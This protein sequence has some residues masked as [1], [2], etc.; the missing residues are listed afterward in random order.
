MRPLNRVTSPRMAKVTAL[1]LSALLGVSAL[2]A[3]G[4]SP[5]AGATSAPAGATTDSGPAAPTQLS[6]LTW[7]DT[8]YAEQQG[9]VYNKQFPKNPVDLKV[10]SGG[11]NDSDSLDKFRLALSANSD[12]PDIVQM[13]YSSLPEFAESGALADLQSSVSP[14]LDGVTTAGQKLMQYNGKYLAV[15]YEVKTK[16][17]FYRS[18]LFQK[19][20][21]DVTKVKTQADFVAAGKQLQAVS[22]KSS[23]WNIGPNIAA[24]NLGMILSG[25]GAKFS[26]KTPTCK[27]TVDSDPGVKNGFVALKELRDSGVVNRNIDDWSPEWQTALADG[28]IASTLN[29]SWFPSFLQQYAPDLAGKWAV[30]TWPEI[31]GA[32]GGS[33]AAGSIFVIPAGAKHKDAAAAFLAG[34]LL[35]PTGAQAYVD[36]RGGSFPSAVKAVDAKAETTPNPYFG[37]SLAKAFTASSNNYTV[38]PYDPAGLKEAGVA[39]AQLVNYLNSKDTDPSSYL[40]TAQQELQSQVGCPFGN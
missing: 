15:P 34:T 10:V 3:C 19:A 14:Y 13:N 11:Q 25:N 9:Q 30:T 16:L 18:D 32:N 33:E 5:S 35:D 29:A 7:G 31:G 12:I 4:G 37:D 26:E 20:G 6:L 38:F 17:W 27:L 23:M 21:I 28:T 2:A 40:A 22:P 1:S 8:K 36:A 24:Y 39:Q